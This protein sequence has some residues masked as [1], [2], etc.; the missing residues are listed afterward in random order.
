MKI[1]VMTFN[2]AIKKD[3]LSNME[4]HSSYITNEKAG[5]KAA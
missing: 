4:R 1:C 2:T 3:A 5:C